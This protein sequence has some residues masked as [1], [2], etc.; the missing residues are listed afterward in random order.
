MEK[1]EVKD[2]TVYENRFNEDPSSFNDFQAMDYVKELKNQGRIDEAIE[3]GRT[4]LQ[5]GE[6]LT[7][8]INH[9]AYALYNKFINITDEE[10]AAKENLFYS[11]LKEITS[12]C[13]Q[14]RYSP[15]EVTVNKALKYELAKESIDYNKVLELLSYLDV[16]ELSAEPFVNKE[17]K[18]FESKKERWFKL[19]IRANYELGQYKQ[20]VENT[21]KAFASHYKWHYNNLN[22]TKY[23]RASSLVQLGEYE[24]AENEF[25][26]LGHKVPTGD[27]F[28]IL[29]SLYLNTHKEKE[30]YTQLIYKFFNEGYDI[31]CLNT[32]EKIVD[33]AKTARNEEIQNV[34]EAFVYKLKEE[35][36]I[37][38]TTDIHE[39]YVNKT[40]SALY[41]HL[42][43]VLME[44]LDLFIE[45]TE[46]KVVYYNEERMF[47]SIDQDA[48]DNLF[49]RQADYIYDEI[50]EKYDIVEYSIMK[51]YDM[52]KQRATYKAI[53][54]K[55]VEEGNSYQF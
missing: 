4:F 55:T 29:Y 41:D 2:L 31:Q 53:L 49:L 11:I 36:N 32:Y 44:H 3:A 39:H 12:L 15:L 54:L 33:M 50:V 9:Y 46:G 26:A 8:F 18:E 38:N 27:S 47:G 10:I 40:S 48:E 20:C 5:V 22:W 51:T 14:E 21:N 7:G 23:Y 28:E 30:A 42:Y 37:E 24:E 34:A 52:K 17:G 45:R 16:N 1:Q 25:L 19:A 13:K 6:N 43:N 35:N